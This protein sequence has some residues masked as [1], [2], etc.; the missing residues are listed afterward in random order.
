METESL[1][2]MCAAELHAAILAI[3]QPRTA[4]QLTHFVV[5]QHDTE[6]RRWMQ[7]V[8]ELQI[9]LQCLRR[10]Q[11]ERR[12]ALRQI[13]ALRAAG[14]PDAS[15]EAELLEIDLE[16]QALA[17]VGA[18]RETEVLLA[19]FRSFP[20]QYTNAELNAAEGVYWQQRLARQAR[21]GLVATGRVGAGDL[22]ALSQVG[23]PIG[24][25]LI[26]QLEAQL[27]A[28]PPV[29]P[30]A[31]CS[32]GP[33]RPTSSFPADFPPPPMPGDWRSAKNAHSTGGDAV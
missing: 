32:A 30:P 3:Q 2:Q 4:F 14:T 23:V 9:K 12:R 1:I 19:I 7:C 5:G 31:I 20:R 11:V 24:P 22:D 8:L 6:P 27:C 28:S 18:V 10:A 13:A 25:D 16:A 17:V 29:S 26:R 15:D 33:S 21:H